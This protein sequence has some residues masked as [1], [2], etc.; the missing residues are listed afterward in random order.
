MW[1]FFEAAWRWKCGLPEKDS[2]PHP[3]LDILR[4]TEWCTEFERLM[5]NRL[6]MGSFR[7][8]CLGEKGKPKW[9]RVSAIIKRAE[10]YRSSG[11][12]EML[13][14]IA[15][16]CL[17]EFVEGDGYFTPTDGGDHVKE[18]GST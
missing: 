7:Y 2:K 10:A 13:V 4:E 9:D 14:D 11:N 1:R 3:P 6:I 5:R 18:Y 17:L 16:F 12:K 15:N 8:G